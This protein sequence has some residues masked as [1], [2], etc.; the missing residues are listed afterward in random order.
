MGSMPS[1]SML[2]SL[3]A[4]SEPISN[5]VG[6]CVITYLRSIRKLLR[7][8]HWRGVRKCETSTMVS[9]KAGGGGASGGGA[10]IHL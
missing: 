9:E 6:V 2:D 7:D 10:E 3:L 8:R 5:G 4:K 1:G